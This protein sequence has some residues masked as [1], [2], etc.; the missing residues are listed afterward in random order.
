MLVQVDDVCLF[1]SKIPLWPFSETDGEN[2]AELECDQMGITLASGMTDK[3]S[4]ALQEVT[5]KYL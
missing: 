5:S 3:E 1:V 4:K 2:L